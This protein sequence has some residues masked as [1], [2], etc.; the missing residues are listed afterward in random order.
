MCVS[1]GHEV[2]IITGS[3]WEKAKPY[4]ES[5]GY[6]EGVHFTDFFSI[7]DYH[8]S[9]DTDIKTDVNGELWLDDNT[10]NETKSVYCNIHKIDMHFDDG[11]EYGELF[12]TPFTLI[13]N[14]K[15][16]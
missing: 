2:H 11:S 4:L 12:K 9:I 7:L 10:W 15:G 6:I 5:L 1:S 16:A 14:R 3:K 13:E 8:S